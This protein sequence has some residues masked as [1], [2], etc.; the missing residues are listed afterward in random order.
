MGRVHSLG[1]ETVTFRVVVADD[2]VSVRSALR[3]VLDADHRFHVVGL[4][5]SGGELALVAAETRPDVV[6]M[7]VRMPDGGVAAARAVLR[8]LHADDGNR[9]GSPPPTVIAVSAH[10][11]VAL[12]VA[13]M[14]AG[15]TGFLAK[16]RLGELPDL[17][18]RCAA[19]EVVLA[20]PSGAEALRQLLHPSYGNA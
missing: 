18:A 2:D 14:R 5:A 13:M 20:V 6:L 15:A 4:A 7:D 10:I 8:R 11:G 17:V 16:G 9:R 12:V 3:D 19:G 1:S